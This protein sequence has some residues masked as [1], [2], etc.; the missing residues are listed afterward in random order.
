MDE[1]NSAPTATPHGEPGAPVGE[2]GQTF[3]PALRLPET[4][5]SSP[6]RNIIPQ[7]SYV[8]VNRTHDNS[9]RHADL[10]SRFLY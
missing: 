7:R 8:H 10:A 4:H 3:A 9:F 5:P 2:G 6:C 1:T